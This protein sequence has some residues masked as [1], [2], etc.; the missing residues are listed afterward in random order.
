MIFDP[1]WHY[2]SQQVLVYIDTN[3]WWLYPWLFVWPYMLRNSS[4]C[5][6]VNNKLWFHRWKSDGNDWQNRH[7]VEKFPIFLD[8]SFDIRTFFFAVQHSTCLAI[9]FE[10]CQWSVGNMFQPPSVCFFRYRTESS[11]GMTIIQFFLHFFELLLFGFNDYLLGKA[12]RYTEAIGI[13]ILYHDHWK[14]SFHFPEEYC[15]CRSNPS[16]FKKKVFFFAR[17]MSR[18]N[19]FLF[20]LSACIWFVTKYQISLPNPFVTLMKCRQWYDC[21]TSHLIVSGLW[22]LP[23]ESLLSKRNR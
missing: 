20:F 2:S 19:W 5:N 14:F 21:E 3:R 13:L 1:S 16:T 11:F 10:F 12:H 7:N 6:I 17:N 9:S 8:M 18:S 4:S 15:R 23:Y 22:S